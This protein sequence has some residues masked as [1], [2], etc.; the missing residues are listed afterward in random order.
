MRFVNQPAFCY[1]LDAAVDVPGRGG[2]V[3][4]IAY[5]GMTYVLV[6]AAGTGLRPEPC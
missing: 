1:H 6:D 3:V 2:L 5:G 4:D